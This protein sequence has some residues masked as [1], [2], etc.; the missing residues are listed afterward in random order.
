MSSLWPEIGHNLMKYP[1]GHPDNMLAIQIDLRGCCFSD[2]V[3]P[4]DII[5]SPRITVR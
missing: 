5:P 1:V 2:N 3:R 4:H